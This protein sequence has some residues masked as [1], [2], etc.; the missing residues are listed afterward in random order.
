MCHCCLL[1][2]AFLAH[3]FKWKQWSYFLLSAFRA[4]SFII[5]A[6]RLLQYL[7]C[8]SWCCVAPCLLPFGLTSLS[9]L[10]LEFNLGCPAMCRLCV[11]VVV[12]DQQ[13]Q[14][15]LLCIYSLHSCDGL[16]VGTVSY[17]R[18]QYKILTHPFPILR[19]SLGSLALLSLHDIMVHW[20]ITTDQKHCQASLSH[21]YIMKSGRVWC[22]SL[23]ALKL[24]EDAYSMICTAPGAGLLLCVQLL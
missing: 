1:L 3:F 21:R 16:Q 6:C 9:S 24:K 5:G 17:F 7:C 11:L 23:L 2:L 15:N 22:Y 4:H 8:G 20:A 19:V 14:S 10:L 13:A 18:F 12:T